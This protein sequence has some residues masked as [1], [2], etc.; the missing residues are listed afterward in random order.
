MV[1]STAEERSAPQGA[2]QRQ[3]FI[4][5]NPGSSRADPEA[6]RAILAEAFQ[7][8]EA[9]YTLHLIEEGEDVPAT[10][11]K[12]VADGHTDI[13]AAG[14]DGTISA[15]ATGLLGGEA[16]LGILPVGTANVLAREFNIPMDLAQAATLIAK[17]NRA[18]LVDAM[19]LPDR[20]AL[21]QID[22]GINS[23]MIRDTADWA[24][25]LVG[26]AAYLWT[27]FT[28]LLGFQPRRFRIAVDGHLHRSSGLQV[29]VANAG[30]LGMH[31]FRWGPDIS[32]SDGQIDVAIL[33]AHTLADTAHLAWDLLLGRQRQS[34]RLRY[35]HARHAIHVDAYPPLPVQAD[36]EII[37]ETP[38]TIEV[39]PSAVSVIVPLEHEAPPEAELEIGA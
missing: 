34:P 16:R 8:S 24:K 26:R 2:A 22:V 32:P 17:A 7:E 13:V 11:R 35:L 15:V 10:V 30:L 27:A 23:V 25:K 18:I 33:R 1:D 39:H 38:C 31:P 4:V 6:M 5:L 21:L 14:G 36:G 12:A 29:V 3:V 19:L 37:G 9:S 28:R 20:V